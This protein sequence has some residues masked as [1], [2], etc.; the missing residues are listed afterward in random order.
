[1]AIDC[2]MQHVLGTK[3]EHKIK[4]KNINDDVIIK[5]RS[6]EVFLNNCIIKF[7]QCAFPFHIDYQGNKILL[8]YSSCQFPWCYEKRLSNDCLFGDVVGPLT[9]QAVQTNWKPRVSAVWYHNLCV[10]GPTISKTKLF[11]LI[12]FIFFKMPFLLMWFIS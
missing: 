5:W 4:F 2:N 6:L 11:M 12:I 7:G 3:L 10:I 1:M 9:H 8:L